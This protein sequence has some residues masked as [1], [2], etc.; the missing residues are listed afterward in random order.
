MDLLLKRYGTG[1]HELLAL[2][3]DDFFDQ[4]N[5]AFKQ[6]TEDILMQRWIVNHEKSM[7]FEEFKN[8]LGIKANKSINSKNTSEVLEDVHDIINLFSKERR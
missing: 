3:I 8:K 6:H 7:S 5:Y 1:Y 2:S 4:I